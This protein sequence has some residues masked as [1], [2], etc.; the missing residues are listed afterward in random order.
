MHANFFTI[1]QD[2]LYYKNTLIWTIMK[3]SSKN[4]CYEI[5]YENCIKIL[6]YT[7]LIV[8]L[9]FGKRFSFDV[10][11]E[12]E[13]QKEK[14][15]YR[16]PTQKI[17]Y[18]SLIISCASTA[19]LS[20]KQVPSPTHILLRFF[21]E[22]I[23]LDWMTVFRSRVRTLL[24]H[25]SFNICLYVWWRHQCLCLQKMKKSRVQLNKWSCFYCKVETKG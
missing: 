6:K 14:K 9:L 18:F 15:W 1:N 7:I 23:M 12:D 4:K 16:R 2:S 19:F 3:Q 25:N 24:E 20:S 5:L 17:E 10:C 21:S 11:D 8:F 22:S 13:N